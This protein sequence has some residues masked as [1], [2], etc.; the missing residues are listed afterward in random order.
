MV[1]KEMVLVAALLGVG[2]VRLGGLEVDGLAAP[3][4]LHLPASLTDLFLGHNTVDFLI[5]IYRTH[6][7]G[8]G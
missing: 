7:R 8:D 6:G 1:E 3:R 5:Y 4:S 2:L